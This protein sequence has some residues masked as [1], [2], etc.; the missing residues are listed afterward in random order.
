MRYAKGL[1]PKLARIG[2]PPQEARSI[3]FVWADADTR[4]TPRLRMNGIGREAP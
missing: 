2:S 1:G 3:V 4:I